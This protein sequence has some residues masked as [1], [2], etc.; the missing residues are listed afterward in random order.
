MQKPLIA[1]LRYGQRKYKFNA[2]RPAPNRF[3]GKVVADKKQRILAA[4]GVPDTSS[5]HAKF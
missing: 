3:H 1:G 5:S 4:D 2:W